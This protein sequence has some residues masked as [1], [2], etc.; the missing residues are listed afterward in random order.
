MLVV[1][2]IQPLPADISLA[3]DIALV[4]PYLDDAVVLHFHLQAAVLGAEDTSG[5]V[6][7]SHDH[8]F[9]CLLIDLFQPRP[10]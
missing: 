5:P 1:G 6:Y 2:D 7:C 9:P 3:A 4:S 8:S 10:A